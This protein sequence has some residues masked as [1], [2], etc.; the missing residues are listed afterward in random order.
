[1]SLGE[2]GYTGLIAAGLSVGNKN[3]KISE[4]PGDTAIADLDCWRDYAESVYYESAP[5]TDGYKCDL[6]EG[7]RYYFNVRNLDST[8]TTYELKGDGY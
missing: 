3:M 8:A 5:G 4:I 2:G 6:K 7:Y 1:M